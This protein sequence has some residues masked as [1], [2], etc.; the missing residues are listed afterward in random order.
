MFHPRIVTLIVALM[1]T[2]TPF[3]V[4]NVFAKDEKEGL[5]LPGSRRLGRP[6]AGGGK[7]VRWPQYVHIHIYIYINIYMYVCIYNYI[8]YQYNRFLYTLYIYI[9]CIYTYYTNATI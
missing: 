8:L 7:E 6:T 3:F 9:Y 4:A 2:L 5:R 1:A